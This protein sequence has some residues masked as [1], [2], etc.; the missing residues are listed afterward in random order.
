MQWDNKIENIVRDAPEWNISIITGVPSWVQIVLERIIERYKLKHIHDLWPELKVYIH[1][2]IRAEPYINSIN[3]LFGE[4]VYWYESYLASEGF[5][6]FKQSD[7]AT[8]MKLI[9]SDNNFFEFIPFNAENFDIQVDDLL[10]Q[11]GSVL[12]LHLES[13]LL[14]IYGLRCFCDGWGLFL[15]FC[16][17]GFDVL[18][19]AVS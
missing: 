2:G 15:W 19:Q 4:K 3:G 16:F 7:T 1:S 18:L 12:L 9:L 14:R 11:N 17:C 5:F 10:L 13:G 8:G 6:A